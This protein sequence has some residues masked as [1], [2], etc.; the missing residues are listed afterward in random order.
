MSIQDLLDTPPGGTPA[1]RLTPRSPL[2][3]KELTAI[4]ILGGILWTAYDRLNKFAEKTS[5]EAIASA[6]MQM[7]LDM[8]HNFDVLV[9]KVDRLIEAQ[10]QQKAD[11]EKRQAAEARR[12]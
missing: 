6:Q 3:V 1:P 11:L 12:K 7:R 2:S 9:P 4:L 10:Q 8:Q 5:V